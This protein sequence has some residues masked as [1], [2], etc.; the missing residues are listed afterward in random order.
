[1]ANFFTGFV[2]FGTVVGDAFVECSASD[3][4][5]QPVTL[6]ALSATGAVT[7]TSPVTFPTS[8][9][10]DGSAGAVGI[11]AAS[12]G[13]APLLWWPLSAVSVIGAGQHMTIGAADLSPTF[14][15]LTT[16]AQS[17][18]IPWSANTVVGT[19]P[20]GFPVTTGTYD[21]VLSGV[22]TAGP[23]V[24]GSSGAI[25]TAPLV[26]GNGY[27]L[28]PVAIAGALTF[29][30]GTLSA[31]ASGVSVPNAAL[32]GGNGTVFNGV[33]IGGGLALTGGTL[34]STGS[35]A[36][37][38]AG[39]VVSNGTSLAPAT[40]G[41]GLA[42]A[43]GTLSNTY[44]LTVP[45]ASLL[46]GSAGALAAVAIGSGLNLAAGTLTA[47]TGGGGT[48][49]A[50][51]AGGILSGGTITGAGT[52][53][54]AAPAAGLVA[55]N[56]SALTTPTIGAGLSYAGGTLSNTGITSL[57]QGTNVTITGGNTISATGGGG[58]WSA[59]PVTAVG[60]GLT[61]SG[62]TISSTAGGGSVTSVVAGTGLT[63]GTITGAGTIALAA[64]AAGI[65]QSNGTVLSAA[66][67][68][69]G[70]TFSGGT[71]SNAGLTSIV[72]GTNITITGGNT[73]SAAGPIAGAGISVSGETITNTGITSLAAGTGIAVASNTISL[74]SIAATSLLG[75][76]G[77]AAAAPSALTIGGGLQ[78]SGGTLSATAAGGTITN[79][80]TNSTYAVLSTDNGKLVTINDGTT[81]VAV[82]LAAAGSVGFTAQW[83]T[84]LLYEGTATATVTTSSNING[85]A[86][87]VTLYPGDLLNVVSDGTN[88]AGALA[89][90]NLA[91]MNG[92]LS[93]AHGGTGATSIAGGVVISNGTSLAPATLGS[94]LTLSSGTLSAAGNWSA[95]AVNTLGTGITVNAGTISATGT[96]G[97][98][99]LGGA[100]G[101][102]AAG[103][104]ITVSAGTISATGTA[105]V[106]SIG[107]TSGAITL[108]TGLAIASGTLSASGGGGTIPQS[109][110]AGFIMS[111]DG[112]TPNT[113]LDFTAGQAA[114]ST[115]A[116]MI[117]VAAFKK[118]TGAFV[119]GTGNGALDT[120]TVAASTWY[121]V[122]AISNAGGTTTDILF[123]L[124]ATAPTMPSTYTLKRRIGSFRTDASA[125]ILPF[126]QVGDNFYWTSIFTDLNNGGTT[127]DTLALFT[128][129]VPTGVTVRPLVQTYFS[130]YVGVI[131]F[132]SAANGNAP[133][134][135]N[136]G[137]VQGLGQNTGV[138][139]PPVFYTNTSAQLW[140]AGS[141]TAA[142][143]IYFSTLGWVDDR[144]KYT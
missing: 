8:T 49:T 48:V 127:S 27:S 117:S 62:G 22:L 31:S 72:G 74:G 39:V 52:I 12:T 115:N 86:G 33:A 121:H 23:V 6:P 95:A 56:G 54:L 28:L 88:Y 4:L 3:Y 11:F 70:L 122:F 99:S 57:V 1:M 69:G 61:V 13:G 77:T 45:N 16:A 26:G 123:S 51:V 18:T 138:T 73:I 2:G 103:A 60:S 104:G 85:Q 37:P 76:G 83:G 94:G 68:G 143:G 65:V 90:H 19:M 136:T 89:V 80:Q 97:V 101:A 55:S 67:I 128:F 108:G 120:G 32:V 109:H 84:S 30:N 131:N 111:N 141:V 17:T 34:A 135:A 24:P 87:T 43:G 114:D 100:T 35:L 132:A 36:V 42:Y 63:G 10:G 21:V 118:T 66:T 133:T 125:H 137:I 129:T 112:T 139:V 81:A 25:P 46:G 59:T 82:S 78:L 105:G 50:V 106:S 20:S 9:V 102:I 144:G 58:N 134:W 14:P 64:P 142:S 110:L 113:T 29:S 38:G 98:T 124:S 140:F 116:V 41:A 7:S 5:R 107:G 15:S 53:S 126:L 44:S 75:N 119:A 91:S 79:A 96:A 92:T 130:N 93:I 47:T 71:L 40:I